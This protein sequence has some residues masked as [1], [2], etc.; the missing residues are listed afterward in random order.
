MDGPF[1]GNPGKTAFFPFP[2]HVLVPD[3]PEGGSIRA[4]IKGLKEIGL[5]LAIFADQKD[6]LS[7]DINFRV[8]EVAECSGSEKGETH[9]KKLS[10]TRFPKKAWLP[11]PAAW[12]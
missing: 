9:V 6:I 5:A 8:T 10:K 7:P 3:A 12:A 2:D 1:Q 11:I 4:K